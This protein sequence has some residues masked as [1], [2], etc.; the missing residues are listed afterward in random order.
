MQ[1]EIV[2]E[3][4]DL[5]VLMVFNLKREN[6]RS[7]LWKLF[8]AKR[9]SGSVKGIKE[10]LILGGNLG[11]VYVFFSETSGSVILCGSGSTLREGNRHCTS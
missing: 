5:Y 10:L 6:L 11:G 8:P 1:S 9:I 4:L 2:D 3:Y 7:Q